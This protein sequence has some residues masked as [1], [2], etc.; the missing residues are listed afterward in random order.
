MADPVR[1]DGFRDLLL[2]KQIPGRIGRRLSIRIHE[3]MDL[4]QFYAEPY[5]PEAG[6]LFVR[7]LAPLIEDPVAA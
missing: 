1:V 4:E 2:H 7:R 6:E 5:T 3:P